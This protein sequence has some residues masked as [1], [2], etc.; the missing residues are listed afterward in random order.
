MFKNKNK[1]ILTLAL[2]ILIFFIAA[3]YI[4]YPL[5]FHLSEFTT[6]FGDELLISW[7]QNHAIYSLI[8]DPALL[9]NGNI[10]YPYQNTIAYSD[11]FLTSSVLSAVPVYLLKEPI[12]AI[13]FTLFSSLFILGFSVFLL[14][15]Y[16]TKN[17]LASVVSGLFVV[18]SPAVLDKKVHLQVLAIMGVPL[19]I[20]FFI[21]F[22]KSNKS[23]WLAMSMF[24]F[25]IQTANS[26]LPGYFLIFFFADCLLILFFKDRKKLRVF[27]QKK[28]LVIIAC[29]LLIL[30]PLVIPY[31]KVANE[32]SF[33]RD[34]RD[35]IHFALQ[36]EDFLVAGSD[37]KMQNILPQSLRVDTFKNG[38]I[39]PGFIGFAFTILSLFS[40]V[41]FLKK[42]KKDI[43]S[44]S[45][46]LTGALGLITS[47]GPA[48]HW[49]RAT[50]HDPFVIPLPYA[51]FYYLLPGF[52]G[53]R[54]SARWEMLFIL[55]FA[56]LI[57]IM[58][59][60]ASS[61][62]GNIK[63]FSM[64]ILII[65][66]TIWEFNFPM[67]FYKAESIHNFPKVYNYISMQNSPSIFIPICN[68]NDKCT[69]LE[70]NR[71]YYSISGYPKMV[72]GTSGFSPPQWQKTIQEINN[73]FPGDSSLK[74]IK[75]MGARYVI[76]E[77]KAWEKYY[78]RP[79]LDELINNSKVKLIKQFDNIY[80]FEL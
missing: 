26:F 55:C 25:I 67:K 58:L 57:A 68:W 41:Y 31:I 66:L 11:L 62:L 47:L 8:H 16:L 7:I 9:F 59:H 80:V 51:L 5:I 19:S 10:F 24:F 60:E 40:V 63:R 70:F 32:F 43:V 38:E 78:S 18:F 44:L 36:P 45:M 64:F 65:V 39:K 61:R 42:K 28:N 30:I 29:A 72:N 77:K 34:I 13:N 76:F 37:S 71:V 49:G 23:K 17:F 73:S 12:T 4:T 53:F 20:M 14:S 33:K 2:G 56:V 74:T 52:S 1:M 69:G 22:L 75:R 48:L 35:S 21:H 6:G 54:N 3:V 79:V 50:I 15:Y 27:I 46:L